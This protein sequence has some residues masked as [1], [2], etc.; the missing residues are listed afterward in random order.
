MS[1]LRSS[2]SAESSPPIAMPTLAVTLT[3][4]CS[5]APSTKGCLSASSRRSAT[6]SGP[7][8]SESSSEM[9]TNSSPPSR[10]SASASRM[11]PSRRAA[12][13]CSSSS[14]ALWPRVSLMSLKLSMSMKSAAAGVWL[15]R[16]RDE[17]LLDPI[18][19]QGAVRQ[20][21]QRVVGGEEGELVLAPRQLLVGSLPLDL[22]ALAHPQQA[23]L[24]AQLQDVEG[25]G[26]SLGRDLELARRSPSAPR[27]SRCARRRSARSPRSAKPRGARPARRRS[28]R[29]PGRP[30]SR[31]P[32]SRRRSSGR[33]RSSSSC[34]SVRSCPGRWN[35]LHGR[36]PMCARP[37]ARAL[38][39][40]DASA[41]R[42]GAAAPRPASQPPGP[43]AEGR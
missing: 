1:A 3:R 14:P 33:R 39:P 38:R 20:S 31:P 35:R 26:E 9:T 24:E 23:E 37:S 16:E 27:P 19:D 22:E 40:H 2:S 8:S 15:R 4:V 17:H 10:P 29:F 43:A 25:L 7:A 34:R 12:T 28:P 6:S 13:A 21:G 5:S 32:C 36:A 18:Q 30:R 42:R 11:T 41:P